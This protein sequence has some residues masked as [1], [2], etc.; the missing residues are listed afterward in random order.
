MTDLRAIA[1]PAPQRG[2][3]AC[4]HAVG[5]G[6]PASRLEPSTGRWRLSTT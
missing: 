1:K 3:S 5:F 2:D 6:M 4:P